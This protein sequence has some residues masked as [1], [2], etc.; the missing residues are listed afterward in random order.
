M[1]HYKCKCG[2]T[3]EVGI[4]V[5]LIVCGCGRRMKKAEQGRLQLISQKKEDRKRSSA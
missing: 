3:C 1:I 2:R 5:K 4:P